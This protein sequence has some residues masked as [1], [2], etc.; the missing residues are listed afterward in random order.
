MPSD[1]APSGDFYYVLDS[2]WDSAGSYDQIGIASDNG[3]WGWVWSWTSY[4]A[5]TY[6]FTTDGYTLSQGASYAF[7]MQDFSNGSVEFQLYYQYVQS[8]DLLA[9]HWAHT[10]GTYFLEQS[11][12]SCSG[13]SYYD[14][15]DYE[16]VYSLAQ[17]NVPNWS[18]AFMGNLANGASVTS[19]AQMYVNSPSAIYSLNSGSDVTVAN[20]GWWLNFFG[21][22]VSASPDEVITLPAEV[23]TLSCALTGYCQNTDP[24][25]N[26]APSGWSTSYSPTSG[27][28]TFW[29][30]VTVHVG[31]STGTYYVD[32]KTTNQYVYSVFYGYYTTF[33]MQFDVRSG[34]GC[35]AYGTPILT[36]TGY[37]PVQQLA[38]GSL[39]E[40]YDI[41]SGSL[42]TGALLYSNASQATTLTDVNAGLLYLTPTDQPVYVRNA[43]FTGWLLDPQNLTVGDQVFDAQNGS[44]ISVTSVQTVHRHIQVYDVVTSGL[45]DFIANGILLD[46][47]P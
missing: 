8:G 28:P 18:F 47:K 20:Q 22:V 38:S 41:G 45:N 9:T 34:G 17:Q 14:Y 5:G 15:T 29:F 39:V 16:E 6:Y 4:C 33:R 46:R 24:S 12:Y 44:W 37:V 3:V 13:N 7:R 11:S 32:F 42:V 30:N 1:T 40:E 43:T 27:T 31:A 23:Q 2:I 25:T 10:G 36:P 19:W 35:V 21:N 26:S